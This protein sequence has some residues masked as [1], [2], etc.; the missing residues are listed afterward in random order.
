M[1]ASPRSGRCAEPRS[2]SEPPLLTEP[3][4][5]T[6]VPDGFQTPGRFDFNVSL[7][8]RQKYRRAALR[9]ERLAVAP[10]E[11][12]LRGSRR[13]A[14]Y[15][16]NTTRLTLSAE[17]GVWKDVALRARL[18]VVLSHSRYI[19]PASSSSEPSGALDGAPGQ[20]LFA[21]P[22]KS[23]IR[24]G[25]EYLGVGADFGLLNQNE[26]PQFPTLLVGV[27]LRLAV[28]EPMRACEDEFRCR[29]PFD[30][31]REL[32]AGGR[33]DAETGPEGRSAGV[34]RGTNGVEA[35]LRMSR[36]IGEIEPYWGIGG[37]LELDT[38]ESE[39]SSNRSWNDA[40]PWQARLDLGVEIIPWEMLENF[41]R[42]SFD[43]RI[44][45][46]HVSAGQDYSELFDALGS[47]AAPTYRLPQYAATIEN[48][49]P[50]TAEETPRVVDPQSERVYAT[51]LT[52]VAAHG[53]L[54]LELGGHWRVGR[55]VRFD[56]GGSLSVV[57]RHLITAGGR[58]P[59]FRVET[60][61]PGRRFSVDTSP[62]IDGWVRSTVLF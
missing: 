22:F 59:S 61:T 10:G 30:P 6:D 13:V 39:F 43:V 19:D 33:V 24:S 56:F 26:S 21:V 28:S 23:P 60:D 41:Q 47:S 32:A 51:G 46:R 50:A 49:N 36:R 54:E 8:Y 20:P 35:H 18:P 14:T 37:L 15:E 2:V 16:E 34:G 58:G 52:Q 12:V 53:A 17:M 57:Q 45:G 55:Y 48:E 44:T 38:E 5:F 4:R 40:P 31:R 42:F 7:G 11:G 25:V 3:A 9:R 62:G 29:Q 1:V 27:E